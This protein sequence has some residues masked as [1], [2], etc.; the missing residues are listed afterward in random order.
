MYL[1]DRQ[2]DFLLASTFAGKVPAFMARES[3]FDTEEGGV[4]PAI[5]NSD[6]KRRDRFDAVV[7]RVTTDHAKVASLI[8]TAAAFLTAKQQQQ[9]G[10]NSSDSTTTTS[11]KFDQLL[12]DFQKSGEHH[13][14]VSDASD[15]SPGS[16]EIMLMKIKRRRVQISR[17]IKVLPMHDAEKEE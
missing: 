5:P 3:G 16:K 7:A 8:E 13:E 17:A 15:I 6:R 9:K 1:L 11:S 4:L 10:E 12:I 14:R 2:Q